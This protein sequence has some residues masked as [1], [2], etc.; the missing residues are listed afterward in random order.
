M[1]DITVAAIANRLMIIIRTKEGTFI[2]EISASG[3]AEIAAQLIQGAAYI[4][5]GIT[6]KDSFTEFMNG[7]R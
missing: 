6:C 3:A 2:K 7:F 1:K 4:E 5:S